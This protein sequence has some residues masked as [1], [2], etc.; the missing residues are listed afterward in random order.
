MRPT[1]LRAIFVVP[2]IVLL[3]ASGNSRSRAGRAVPDTR[4]Q[5]PSPPLQCNARTSRSSCARSAPCRPSNPSPSAPASTARS[6]RFCSPKARIVKPG[7]LLAQ[8]D[9]RPYQATLDQ[10]AR[11]EGRRRRHAG[12][13]RVRPGPLRR[14]RQAA[15]RLTPEARADPGHRAAGHGQRPRRRRQHRHRPAQPR[16]HPH[17][18]A[19]RRPGRPAPGRPRQLHPRR[20]FQHHRHRR[21]SPRSSRS[22]L[23]FTLPQDTLPQVQAAMR[24][25]K[26]PVIAY[27]LRRQAQAE[28]GRAAHHGQRHRHG[29]RHHQA[30]GA[31]PQS[32]TTRCGRVSSSTSALQLDTRKNVP[33]VPS[34]AVAARAE[35]ALR[36]RGHA[37]TT[38]SRCS[39]SSSRRMTASSPCWQA[40]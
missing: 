12:Q 24:R 23:I 31:V 9:P 26:L 22:P 36:L 10:A 35:R 30:E 14:P 15:G 32:P 17:H 37:R 25:G 29:N 5:F 28:R 3:L 34:T 6:T 13:R 18:L 2:A 40:A 16:L 8:L 33:T 27:T 19:D 39:R 20:R 4:R 7:D 11:Q 21:P 38:R 1:R